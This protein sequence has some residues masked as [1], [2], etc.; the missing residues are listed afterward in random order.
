[1]YMFSVSHLLGGIMADWNRSLGIDAQFS[2]V[3][4]R[5]GGGLLGKDRTGVEVRC[6]K[7]VFLQ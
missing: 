7:R 6:D 2:V 3:S 5:G 1:M 4:R